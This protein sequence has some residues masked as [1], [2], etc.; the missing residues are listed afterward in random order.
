[1]RPS[2]ISSHGKGSKAS[3]NGAGEGEKDEE[4]DASSWRVGQHLVEA[5]LPPTSIVGFNHLVASSLSV[6]RLRPRSGF[7]H[8]VPLSLCPSVSLSLCQCL[9]P[10]DPASPALIYLGSPLCLA[11]RLVSPSASSTGALLLNSI[12]NGVNGLWVLSQPFFPIC[13]TCHHCPFK[14]PAL[15]PPSPS[16]SLRVTEFFPVSLY[17]SVRQGVCRATPFAFSSGPSLTS[18]DLFRKRSIHLLL[19][20]DGIQTIVVYIYDGLRVAPLV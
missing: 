4:R 12:G 18:L 9:H 19:P 5:P 11:S 8:P 16:R 10:A 7:D 14:F 2:A 13:S 15:P 3:E 6:P 20:A 17:P 1:M